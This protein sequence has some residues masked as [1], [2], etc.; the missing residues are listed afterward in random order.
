M[1]K[2]DKGDGRYSREGFFGEIIHYDAKGNKIGESRPSLFGGYTDY[3]AKGNKI[4][5]SEE[6][7]LTPGY[8]HYD[9][10]GNKTGTSDESSFGGYTHRDADGHVVGHSDRSILDLKSSEEF[11]ETG[12]I[13]GKQFYHQGGD[14]KAPPTEHFA[15]KSK[16]ESAG[17]FTSSSSYS[18]DAE[19]D[20]EFDDELVAGTIIYADDMALLHESGYDAIDLELMDA[21]ERR[22]A[23][24]DA[25]VDP[26]MYDF[27]DD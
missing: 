19:E 17:S 21:D 15:E 13:Y 27:Y 25:G 24:E 26:D 10:H 9:N 12:S 5:R 20:E 16:N 18:F 14:L 7:I 4:G 23:L 22:E 2:Q 3:D 1:S 6:N 11:L 8:T